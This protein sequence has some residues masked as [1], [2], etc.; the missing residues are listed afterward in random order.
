MSK[1][2]DEKMNMRDIDWRMV[3]IVIALVIIVSS[4]ILPLCVG[5]GNR[6]TYGV[7]YTEEIG[8]HISATKDAKS[9]ENFV[10]YAN[11]FIDQAEASGINN[12]SYSA[13]GL[14]WHTRSWQYVKEQTTALIM[15]AEELQGWFVDS[16]QSQQLQDVYQEKLDN[17]REG[18]DD[19][20]RNTGVRSMW[21]IVNHRPVYD[22]FWL[23]Y[24]PMIGGA[25]ICLGILSIW[26][27]IVE[28]EAFLIIMGSWVII[29]VTPIIAVFMYFNV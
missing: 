2:G 23:F 14:K 27:G 19:L 5:L 10:L 8:T 22:W 25:F 18:F 16:N 7:E 28:Q 12:D 20:M 21:Y 24:F 4:L 17:I 11:R 9:A 15:R 26:G 6:A 13:I 3:F 29:F 1:K